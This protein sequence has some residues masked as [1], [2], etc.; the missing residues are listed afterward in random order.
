MKLMNLDK[1][2]PACYIVLVSLE[3]IET[4]SPWITYC[5]VEISLSSVYF[6]DHGFNNPIVSYPQLQEELCG[7][8]KP[9]IENACA[10]F[11]LFLPK[12]YKAGIAMFSGNLA[13]I[14]LNIFFINVYLQKAKNTSLWNIPKLLVW[15]S[16]FLKIVSGIFY[17]QILEGNKFNTTWT[18]EHDVFFSIGVYLYITNVF[19]GIFIGYI[20][21][22][23]PKT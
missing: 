1:I 5:N 19:F 23:N 6:F 2:I 13:C 14:L 21:Y 20:V 12:F 22:N 7:K 11:C 16:V 4:F 15:M 8:F 3:V 10:N 9:I 17:F 18:P